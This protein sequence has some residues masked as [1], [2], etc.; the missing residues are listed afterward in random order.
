MSSFLIKRANEMQASSKKFDPKE[1]RLTEEE[2]W[3]SCIHG[4]TRASSPAIIGKSLDDVTFGVSGPH[5]E[6]L[7][8]QNFSSGATFRPCGMAAVDDKY[9]ASLFQETNIILPPGA[10][11]VAGSEFELLPDPNFA[12]DHEIE[13][14]TETGLSQVPARSQELKHSAIFLGELEE[15]CSLPAALRS[16]KKV[17]RHCAKRATLDGNFANISKMSRYNV[18]TL[19]A[20]A[21]Q[22]NLMPSVGASISQGEQD[23]PAVPAECSCEEEM[24]EQGMRNV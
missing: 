12:C 13:R 24:Y 14:S 20:S 3:L 10:P 17:K 1:L 21:T 2:F 15:K 5:M 4:I 22:E 7:K 18:T 9:I 23:T 11:L 19:A 16:V 8:A 6:V